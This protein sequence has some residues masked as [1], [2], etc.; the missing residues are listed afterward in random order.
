MRDIYLK[1]GEAS[2]IFDKT[3]RYY[4]SGIEIEEGVLLIA[5]EKVYFVDARYY[6]AVKLKL[7]KR[8]IKPYLYT[9]FSDVEKVLKNLKI[10]KV[11]INFESV[12]VSKYNEIKNFG[13]EVEDFSER[14]KKIKAQKTELEIK[15]IKK[16]CE[17][18]FRAYRLAL[19]NLRLGVSE[20]QIKKELEEKMLSLG[21]DGIAFDTIV[22]FGKNSAVPHHVS[23]KTRLKENSV[24]L[25]DMGAKYKG[26]CGDLTRTLFFGKPSNEFISRYKQVLTANEKAIAEIKDGI[27]CKQA[28]LIAREYLKEY[29]LEKYFTHSLGH[30][31]GT[32]IHEYP[33]LSP[34]SDATLKDRMVFTIEPGVYFEGEY[35][36][37]IE[38]SVLL[39]GNVKRL[40]V[41]DKKLK[42]IKI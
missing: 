6:S 33:F 25:I 29:N 40:Y 36:I 7:K 4:F 23:G 42:I 9:S 17:I 31:L 2:L 16:A 12:S 30:G 24:V 41:D 21:A 34:R 20:L 38:D 26:Y 32:Q 22:A 39:D 8:N 35:G 3:D 1:K 28:D 37:R 10:E 19:M 18:T 27:S 15:Y 11:Y 13:V 14:L 5:E